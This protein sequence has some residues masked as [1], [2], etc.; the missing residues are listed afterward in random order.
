MS[1]GNTSPSLPDLRFSFLKGKTVLFLITEDW[2]FATHRLRFGVWLVENGVQV[3]VACRSGAKSTEIEALGIRV[4][5]LATS[6]GKTGFGAILRSCSGFRRIVKEIKPDL[7]HVVGLQLIVVAWASLLFFRRKVPVI[8]AIAG[9]GT[10]FSGVNLGVKYRLV[11]GFVVKLLPF[12][13]GSRNRWAV[14]QNLD[15][16]EMAKARNWCEGTQAVLIRGV[17]V[18]VEAVRDDS[19]DEQKE[20]PIKFLFAGRLLRDKGVAELMAASRK[21]NLDGVSHEVEFVGE[22]DFANPNSFTKQ[23]VDAFNELPWINF[24]GRRDDV[25]NRMRQ[26]D[27]IVLPSYREGLPKVLLEAGSLGRPVIAANV[28]GCRE[29]VVDQLNGL[30]VAPRD[31]AS[32]ADAMASLAG[33]RDRRVEM[34]TRNWIRMNAEFSEVII[35]GEFAM[36]YQSIFEVACNIDPKAENRIG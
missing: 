4:V 29:V 20:D 9:M 17:G 18:L 12:I 31:F 3:Y 11:R 16:F 24:S 7:I 10:L 28:E 32:L 36:L 33:D 14:F 8:N 21:L 2:A 1:E 26:S 6:R 23:E 25:L 27:V 35:F 30:L 5:P 15:D 19:R 22:A 13:F 34:G